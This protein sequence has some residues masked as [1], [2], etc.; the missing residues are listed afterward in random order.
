LEETIEN[1]KNSLSSA[2]IRPS[3]NWK[4][5]NHHRKARNPPSFG[6]PVKT[7]PCFFHDEHRDP[8]R[9]RSSKL[10]SQMGATGKPELIS[11]ER[12][13][14]YHTPLLTETIKDL[15]KALSFCSKKRVLT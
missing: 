9:T 13:I 6:S 2:D 15:F 11:V 1:L 12:S 5:Q 10:S 14:R 4:H 3:Q 7:Q 8:A